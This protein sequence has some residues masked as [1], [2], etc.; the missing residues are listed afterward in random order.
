MRLLTASSYICFLQGGAAE[1]GYTFTKTGSEDVEF[2]LVLGRSS[3]PAE[4]DAHLRAFR[5]KAKKIAEALNSQ[6]N[7][8]GC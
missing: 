6:P 4:I 2:N 5:G 1:Y 8:E 3:S 7:V